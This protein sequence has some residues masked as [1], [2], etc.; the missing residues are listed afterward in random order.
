[1]LLRWNQFRH[2]RSDGVHPLLAELGDLNYCRTGTPSPDTLARTGLWIR[3]G[4]LT[5]ETLARMD[6]IS[7]IVTGTSLRPDRKF[8]PVPYVQALE[9]QGSV[10]AVEVLIAGRA[11]PG[12][13][14]P[15]DELAGPASSREGSVHALRS[16]IEGASHDILLIMD[17]R[18]SYQPEALLQVVQGLQST[19]TE[20]AIGVPSRTRGGW[21]L[22]VI[23]RRLLGIA[24]QL[25]LGTSD[26]F[27]GLMAVRR[28][29]LRDLP[30]EHGARGSRLVLDL[31]AWPCREHRD[32]P[33]DTSPDDRI[34]ILPLRFDDVRQLKRVLDHR[35]GTFSRLVQFCMVGASGMVVDLTLYAILQAVFGRFWPFATRVSPWGLS[36][37]LATAGA[38]SIFVALVWNFTLNRRLTFNDARAGSILR[39]FMTYA[40]GNAL[41]IGVSLSLRLYLPM[42]IGFFGRHRLAAAVVGIIVA[43]GISFSMSRWVV[44]I[45]RPAG[46]PAAGAAT[47]LPVK[48][49]LRESPAVS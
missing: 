11:K 17:A 16:A 3:N 19:D 36:W 39:Q 26:I 33:V 25:T 31:L 22:R 38:L 41:G 37:P 34:P 30:A 8:D 32:I 23:G 28:R 40:L 44:F 4:F 46:L 13:S 20:L 24:G 18:R 10:S 2:L 47:E 5:R 49:A 12:D 29:M 48:S 1:M 27:S 43:T 14:A 42:K 9:E 7:L 15:E 21:P 35:F 6:S 45:R